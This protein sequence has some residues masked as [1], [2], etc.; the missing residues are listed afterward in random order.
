MADYDAIFVM[1]ANFQFILKNVFLQIVLASGI[2]RP[3]FKELHKDY[4]IAVKR[5]VQLNG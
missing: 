5:T 4:N 2:H 1:A 3:L